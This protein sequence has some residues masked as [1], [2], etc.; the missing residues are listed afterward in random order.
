MNVGDGL[1]MAID[2]NNKPSFSYFN[3]DKKVPYLYDV[4]TSLV[5][6]LLTDFEGINVPLDYDYSLIFSAINTLGPLINGV[7]LLES[8]K[9]SSIAIDA[10][11]NSHVVFH[12][13]NTGLPGASLIGGFLG[14]DLSSLGESIEN[15]YSK[16]PDWDGLTAIGFETITSVVGGNASLP[17][18]VC[19]GQTVVEMSYGIHNSVAFDNTGSLFAAYYDNSTG[20]LMLAQ[21]S[22][23]SCSGWSVETV[24]SIGNVG[25]YASLGFTSDNTPYIAYHDVSNGTL[26]VA[27]KINNAWGYEIVDGGNGSVAGTYADLAVGNDD[28]IHITYAVT[29]TNPTTQ[30]ESD[31]PN[32]IKYAVTYIQ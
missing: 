4:D 7:F 16:V 19:Y 27:Y 20:D 21:K 12:N 15:Q 26:K 25:Q 30:E 31:H 28:R 5:V 1:S 3:E 14:Y 29:Y 10:Q 23:D 6:D 13:Y 18:G 17:S 2:S 32:I 24:D 8:G 9:Y 22:A 11:N